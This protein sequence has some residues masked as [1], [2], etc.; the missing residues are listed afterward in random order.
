MSV[1]D[2]YK[3][4]LRA[5]ASAR[6]DWESIAEAARTQRN[7]ALLAEAEAHINVCIEQSASIRALLEGLSETKTKA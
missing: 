5:L 3:D 6:D 2:L 7:D 1:H 4:A